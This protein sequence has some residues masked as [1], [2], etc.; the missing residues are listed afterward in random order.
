MQ[1][2]RPEHHV[3]IRRSRNDGFALLAGHTTA[4]RNLNAF[5]LQVFHPTQIGEDFFLGFFTHRAGVEDHQ[6]GLVD[7]GGLFVALG[8][9]QHVGHFVRV[10]LVHLATEGFDKDFAAHD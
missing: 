7:V 5:F 2:L 8:S 4:D 3:H 10:V 1:S 6:V 9:A